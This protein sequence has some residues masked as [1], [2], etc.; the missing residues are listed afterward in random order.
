MKPDAVTVA[1]ASFTRC[2]ATPDFL[3]A[4][5]QNFFRTC[6]AA[7]PMFATIDLTRQARLLQHA[8]GL[9]LAF[10]ATS[11]VEPTV[12]TRLAIKHGP[13]GMNIDPGWY[14]PFL[15]ALVESAASH[16]PDFTPAVAAAWRE[17]VE[18]GMTY[19]QRHGRE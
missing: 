11:A 1:K 17:A 14:A 4:F 3:L 12:L 7:E 15:E 5:Y 19:M 18:P 10:P 13:E 6:P 8:L 16:D 2:L 9:L